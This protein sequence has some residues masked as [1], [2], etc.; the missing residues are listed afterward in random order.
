MP[1]LLILT[2]IQKN[3]CKNCFIL[4]KAKFKKSD[5]FSQENLLIY[6]LM[7]LTLSSAL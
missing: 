2:E 5:N 3:V 6:I 7:N 4:E 1:L